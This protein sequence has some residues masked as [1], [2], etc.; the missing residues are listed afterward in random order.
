MK[1]ILLVLFVLLALNSVQAQISTPAF[2]RIERL[3]NFPSKLL[4][5]RNV[6]VWLPEGYSK[7]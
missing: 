7:M 6:D 1:Q 5:A 2:G 3:E 4:A